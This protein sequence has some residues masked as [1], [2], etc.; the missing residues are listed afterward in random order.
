M[1][2]VSEQERMIGHPNH[3]SRSIAKTAGEFQCNS[4]MIEG[5]FLDCFHAF[6]LTSSLAPGCQLRN[7]TT[8]QGWS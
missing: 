3:L 5:L 4:L 1:S 2:R 8:S 6:L 7:F